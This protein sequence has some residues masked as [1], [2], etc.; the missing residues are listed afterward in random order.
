M[1]RWQRLVITATA[2]GNQWR[3]DILDAILIGRKYRWA[4]D[5]IYRKPVFIKM[6]GNTLMAAVTLHRQQAPLGQSCLW[7]SS[8]IS[9]VNTHRSIRKHLPNNSSASIRHQ[10]QRK[11][12]PSAGAQSP[13]WA[14]DQHE[15]R[16]S[17]NPTQTQPSE[18]ATRAADSP[19]E[20]R[21][22]RGERSPS[23]VA[24]SEKDSG[25]IS[26]DDCSTRTHTRHLNTQKVCRA[27]PDWLLWRQVRLMTLI[28][29]NQ[30]AQV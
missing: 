9:W 30:G 1:S 28:H 10:Q 29:H 27:E 21:G 2:V 17:S 7:N 22:L 5:R 13:A 25:H 4:H 6:C 8:H 16:T 3:P 26:C 11:Q 19:L 15:P 14:Q 18:E 12:R 23:E 20:E 24:V